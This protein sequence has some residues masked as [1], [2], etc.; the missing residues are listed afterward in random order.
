MDAVSAFHGGLAEE[1][2]DAKNDT[3]GECAPVQ[4]SGDAPKTWKNDGYLAAVDI[5]TTTAA[6]QLRSLQDGS[7]LDTFT[8][9]NP[10]GK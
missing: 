6:M 10:Q 9:L 5:G 4:E 8:C 3:M 1:T 7:I 2:E